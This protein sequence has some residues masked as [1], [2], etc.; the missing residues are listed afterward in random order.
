MKLKNLLAITLL[1]FILIASGFALYYSYKTNNT[2]Q[3]DIIFD[4]S[5]LSSDDPVIKNLESHLQKDFFKLDTKDYNSGISFWDCEN[6][7]HLIFKNALYLGYSR[8]KPINGNYYPDF[9]VTILD[10]ESEAAAQKAYILIQKFSQ[11]QHECNLEQGF[12]DKAPIKFIQK[13][14]QVFY[15]STRAEMFRTYMNRYSDFILQQE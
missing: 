4:V 3:L 15:F 5:P 8:T 14:H 9:D 2:N 6:N 11:K 12:F 1:F 10:F 7:Q 13:N